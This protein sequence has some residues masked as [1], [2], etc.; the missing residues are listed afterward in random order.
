M[1]LKWPLWFVASLC[2]S[3]VTEA[4]AAEVAVMPVL[5]VNLAPGDCDAIGVLF[6]NAFA[7]D[8]H[9]AVASPLETKTLRGDGKTSVAVAVQLGVARYVEL[10]ALQLGQRVNLGGIIYVADGAMLYR[11]EI[12]A[13]S[14]DAMDSAISALAHALAWRQPIP[15]VAT[16]EA[17]LASPETTYAAPA[18]PPPDP[19]APRGA[20]GPKVGLAIPR[21]AG[22]SFSPGI[23]IQFDGRLGPR[24]YFLEFGAGL[25]IP[26]DDQ[27]G[28]SVIRVTS[29]FLELGGSYYLWEGNSALYL[30]AGISPAI[31]QS[32]MGLDDHTA[33]TCAAYGQ[34]GV[35]FTRNARARIY[36]EVRLSQLLLGV[37]NPVSDGTM[38]GST[39]SDAYRPTMLAFQ[40]GVG[41]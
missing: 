28:S 17:A 31:W 39:P 4:R 21:A 12:S 3:L 1:P 20:Y 34:V 11:A 22:K 27:T 19:K 25:L 40:G 23:L 24:N 41:W 26:T 32:S 8:A 35:T 36:G 15:T 37:A 16:P 30:G 7:H 38:Y 9:V 10:S 14:L 18:E 6:A 13:P 33:A 29:G 2:A 5:G